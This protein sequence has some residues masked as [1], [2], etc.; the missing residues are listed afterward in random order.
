MNKLFN[1]ELEIALRLLILMDEYNSLSFTKERLICFDFITLYA[2][3][4]N[5]YHK[6]INGDNIFYIS[7]YSSLKQQYNKAIKLL[8]I[9]G[10]IKLHKNN[11]EYQINNLG[12]SFIKSIN[13][14][15]ALQ[16]RRIFTFV[17]SKYNSKDD[18][19]LSNEILSKA[20]FEV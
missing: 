15:Y 14:E 6:N 9:K 19:S 3:N 17:Y 11:F 13:D 18:I 1:S 16:Y 8:L 2:K 10:L 20:I 12:S 7:E 4:F 5:V